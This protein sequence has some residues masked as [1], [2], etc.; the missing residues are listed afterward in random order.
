[1]DKDPKCPSC[2]RFFTENSLLIHLHQCTAR[3]STPNEGGVDELMEVVVDTHEDT[4][5]LLPADIGFDLTRASSDEEMEHD[6]SSSSDSYNPDDTELE[7]SSDIDDPPSENIDDDASPHIESLD[8][9]ADEKAEYEIDDL[10][11]LEDREIEGTDHFDNLLRIM[12]QEM[13]LG[14]QQNGKSHCWSSA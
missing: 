1:M 3:T 7:S 4:S 8:M 6:H 12:D 14:I 5:S 9:P 10:Q 2:H 13:A 11:D